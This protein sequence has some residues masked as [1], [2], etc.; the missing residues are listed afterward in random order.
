MSFED[1]E[2]R[3]LHE[4]PLYIDKDPIFKK[5]VD[6]DYIIQPRGMIKRG[7]MCSTELYPLKKKIQLVKAIRK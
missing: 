6:L 4:K 3:L 7:T 2:E 1:T 5:T